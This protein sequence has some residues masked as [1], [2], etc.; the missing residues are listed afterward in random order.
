MT[1]S[2][3][4]SMPGGILMTESGPELDTR[5]IALFPPGPLYLALPV[6][7][8]SGTNLP[9]AESSSLSRCGGTHF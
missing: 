1:V 7:S 2:T 6:R 5:P 9:S 4:S 8:Q 3:D